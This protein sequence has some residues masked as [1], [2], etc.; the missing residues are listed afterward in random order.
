VT[1]GGIKQ[2]L[3]RFPA[4]EHV[5]QLIAR[6]IGI[7]SSAEADLLYRTIDKR[8]TGKLVPKRPLDA[9]KYRFGRVLVIAGTDH[10]LGAPV[11]CAGGAARIGAGLI[12]VASTRDARLNV[13]AH[14]PEVTFTDPSVPLESYL[15]SHNAIVIGPGLGRGPEVTRFVA[16]VLEQRSQENAIVV[17]ADGLVALSELEHWPRRLGPNAV[18]TPHA[19]ELERLIGKPLNTSETEWAR[20]GRLAREWGCV[21]VAKGPFTAVASPDGHVDVW[22]HANPALATGGTG[23]VLAGITAG[24]L[25]QH[26]APWDAA[27]LAVA[28]HAQAAQNLTGRGWRTLLASDL[29]SELPAVLTQLR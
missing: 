19:G 27:R 10:F 13:A 1:L 12:T 16:S 14:L 7:P 21:L 17:D 5:G 20:A 2:G 9:H 6:E 11:L 15:E 29:L 24:L 4:A 28:V 25:A 23:D 22:P 8:A 18:L 3:L 26:L